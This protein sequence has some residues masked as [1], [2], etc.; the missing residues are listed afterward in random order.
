MLGG[1]LGGGCVPAHMPARLVAPLAGAVPLV[2]QLHQV[3]CGALAWQLP[4]PTRPQVPSTRQWG[5]RPSSGPGPGEAPAPAAGAASLATTAA[6]ST[7]GASSGKVEEVSASDGFAGVSR[8]AR[9]AGDGGLPWRATLA[10]PLSAKVRRP[11]R[12]NG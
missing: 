8:A 3:L 6:V 7:G 1:C 11:V 12:R 10:A 9:G 5:K 2:A 4:P